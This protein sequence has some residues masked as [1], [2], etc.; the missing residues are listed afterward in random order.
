MREIDSVDFNLF[1]FDSRHWRRERAGRALPAMDFCAKG[2]A[3]KGL[4]YV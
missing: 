1:G 4:H 3:G 2:A